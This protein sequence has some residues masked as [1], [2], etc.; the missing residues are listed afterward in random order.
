VALALIASCATPKTKDEWLR[1]FFDGVPSPE[2]LAQPPPGTAAPDEGAGPADLSTPGARLVV[3]APYV[4]NCAGCHV[5]V[6]SQKMVAEG[7][8]LCTTCHDDFKLAGASIHSPAEDGDCLSCH[9]PHESPFKALLVR[10]PAKLCTECHEDTTDAKVKHAPAEEGACADCH[11]PHASPHKHLLK[12]AAAALCYDCHDKFEG[13]AVH[14][15]VEDGDCAS[16]HTPHAGEHKGLLL[17]PG[18]ALCYECH[19]ADEMKEA[20]GHESADLTG[21]VSC[22]DPHRSAKAG[23]LK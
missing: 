23:L 16:C 1:F 18:P 3:H 4:D 14:S 20:K 17:K 13:E 9:A 7:A 11:D 22:H 5:S 8:A 6:H 2:D 12:K 10:E 21:C 15:P 19:D